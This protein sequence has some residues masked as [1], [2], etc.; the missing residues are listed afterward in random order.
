METIII[1]PRSVAKSKVVLDFLKKE[2][3]PVEIY[4]EPTKS[5]ILKSIEKGAKETSQY[6]E[7]KLKLK[8]VKELLREL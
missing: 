3:I 7:G 5:E 1:K 2:K 6:I 4:K 8:G